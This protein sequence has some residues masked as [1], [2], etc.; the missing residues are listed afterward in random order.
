MLK[1]IYF[2]SRIEMDEVVKTEKDEIRCF[3]MTEVR[4][5]MIPLPDEIEEIYNSFLRSCITS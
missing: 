4:Y 5:G 2:L 1:N 3:T